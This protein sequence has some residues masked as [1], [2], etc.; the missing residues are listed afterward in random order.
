LPPAP[1]YNTDIRSRFAYSLFYKTPVGPALGVVILLALAA[2]LVLRVAE[3]L[4]D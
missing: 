2:G 4:A 1:S 3:W